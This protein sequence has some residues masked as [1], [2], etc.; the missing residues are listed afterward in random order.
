MLSPYF[1]DARHP[2]ITELWGLSK[3]NLTELARLCYKVNRDKYQCHY[4]K[5]RKE[6]A[7][8]SKKELFALFTAFKTFKWLA[9]FRLQYYLGL[10]IGE[11][12]ALRW[13]DID[14]EKKKINIWN[15][16]SDTWDTLRHTCISDFYKQTK[17][18]KLTQKLARHKDAQTTFN[19]YVHASTQDLESA[20]NIYYKSLKIT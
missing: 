8:L 14:L 16:K 3:H 10:R 4:N 7:T 11:A 5:A 15:E 18:A 20:L 1:V 13:Q 2:T 9:L 17:D 19:V 12:C 6:Q